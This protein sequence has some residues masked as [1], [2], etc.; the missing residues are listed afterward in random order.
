M[1]FFCPAADDPGP[2]PEEPQH[3]EGAVV[4]EDPANLNEK[5]LRNKGFYAKEIVAGEERPKVNSGQQTTPTDGEYFSSSARTLTIFCE[6]K[7]HTH[8]HTC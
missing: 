5:D 2:H 7:K 3:P 6:K 4:V 8:T 1:F